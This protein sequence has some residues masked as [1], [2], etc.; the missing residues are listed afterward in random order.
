MQGPRPPPAPITAFCS[1]VCQS[2]GGVSCRAGPSVPAALAV[3]AGTGRQC[4]S[5]GFIWDPQLAHLIRLAQVVRV[6][7]LSEVV[8]DAHAIALSGRVGG[9]H[10]ILRGPGEGRPF[11]AAFPLLRCERGRGSRGDPHTCL[12]LGSLVRSSSSQHE[13]ALETSR[14]GCKVKY[15]QAMLPEEKRG[16]EPITWVSHHTISTSKSQVNT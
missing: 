7:I 3:P 16:K 5:V 6:P 10:A 15:C 14:P 1:V 2:A 4:D 9:I 12:P 11:S 8:H 13:H